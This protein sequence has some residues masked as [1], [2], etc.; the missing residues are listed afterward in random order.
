MLEDAREIIDWLKTCPYYYETEKQI[1]VH[2][3]IVEWADED[4]LDVTSDDLM[5][6]KY[7]ASIGSFY[8]D[9]IAGHISTAKIS[10][11]PNFHGVY[12]DRKNHFYVDGTTYKSG[13][14]PVLVYDQEKDKYHEI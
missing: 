13:K 1:F 6:S 2:A 10:G 4:W 12:F 7:P 8:K 14:V 11:D 9:I 3:G 5:V